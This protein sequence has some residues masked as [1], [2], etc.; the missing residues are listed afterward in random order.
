MRLLLALSQIKKQSGFTLLELIVVAVILAI[1]AAIATP[2]VLGSLRD[3]EAKEAYLKIKN[4]L[5]EAQSNADR[6]STTCTVQ[7]T[8]GSGVYNISGNP[9]GCILEPFAIDTNVVSVTKSDFSNPPTNIAFSFRGT[10]GNAST[11]WITRKDFS[12]NPIPNG[13]R[14][15]VVSVMGMIRTGINTGTNTPVCDNPLNKKYDNS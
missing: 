6:Q 7:F 4:A 5:V 1:S 11:L 14:C 15:I 2:N 8:A 10:T 3:K 12:N 9:T 13:G